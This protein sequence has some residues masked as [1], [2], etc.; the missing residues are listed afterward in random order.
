M[1]V[2]VPRHGPKIMLFTY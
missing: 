2:H 1:H